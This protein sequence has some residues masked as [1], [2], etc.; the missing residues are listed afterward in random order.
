MP[1][2]PTYGSSDA[3]VGTGCTYAVTARVTDNRPVSVVAA[4]RLGPN[5]AATV[6]LAT[7]KRAMGGSVTAYWTPRVPGTYYV[8]AF[9]PRT[10]TAS[11]IKTVKVASGMN[12]SGV[13]I[14][15]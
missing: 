14:I 13:C 11:P 3:M 9:Q 4:R 5:Q 8:T 15:F 6:F 12:L 2:G 7:N 1:T 10:R